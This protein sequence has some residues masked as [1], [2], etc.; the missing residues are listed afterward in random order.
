MLEQKSGYPGGQQEALEL[1]E[2]L[3]I[4]GDVSAKTNSVIDNQLAQAGQQDAGQVLDTMT[5]LILGSPEFQMR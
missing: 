5:A 3:L 4:A 2:Q 1:M